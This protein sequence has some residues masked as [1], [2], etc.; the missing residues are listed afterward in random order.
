[1]ATFQYSD[2]LMNAALDNHEVTI[3]TAPIINFWSG[4]MPAHCSTARSGTLLATGTLPSDW[5]GNAATHAKAKAGTWTL[6]GQLGAG[7]GTNAGY[8]EITDS[9]AVATYM[10][11]D[12]T[13]TGG[14]GAMTLDNISIAAAQVITVASFTISA[15]N[16]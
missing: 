9:G 16:A 7:A 2:A 14:G 6:T 15:G 11:G 4:A 8:F 3:G 5:L 13:A 12:I 10:Q 1:M